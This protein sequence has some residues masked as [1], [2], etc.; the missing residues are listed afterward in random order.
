MVKILLA[1]DDRDLS[2]VIVI[3]L[4]NKGHIVKAVFDG[5]ECANYLAV[6]SFDLIILDWMMPKKAGIDVCRE[7]R[8]GGGKTPI[9]ML[10]AKAKIDEREAGLD[11]GADDYLT[12]PFDQRE[13]AA[14]V[15]A[16]LRRP[17]ALVG[18]ILQVAGIKMDTISSK[19]WVNGTE[20]SLRPK[21]YSLLEFFMRHPNQAFAATA[22]LDRVWED[23]ASIDN[24][25]THI[26]M[27]RR[28]LEQSGSASCPLKTVRGKGYILDAD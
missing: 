9:L 15:R 27:L 26:K 3:A 14:R 5:V 28:K 18:S 2:A 7:F 25:K 12:K 17:D 10:T 23:S 19:V 16:L 11:S 20:I 21:E 4:E 8:S 6:S 13:L 22:I 1:E 24:L